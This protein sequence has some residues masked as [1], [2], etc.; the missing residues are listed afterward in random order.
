MGQQPFGGESQSRASR[1]AAGLGRAS[2]SANRIRGH[3][4]FSAVCK[5][6]MSTNVAI[7]GYGSGNLHSAAKAFERAALGEGLT[8]SIAVTREAEKRSRP[9]RAELRVL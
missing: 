2:V 5:A 9:Y 7:I 3:W 8:D 4:A 6:A 1:I